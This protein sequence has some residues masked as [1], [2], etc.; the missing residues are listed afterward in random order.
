MEIP[1]LMLSKAIA[2]HWAYYNKAPKII[3][4]KQ[5]YLGGKS[6]EKT[7]KEEC[8]VIAFFGCGVVLGDFDFGFYLE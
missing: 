2:I 4:G 3:V 6:V 7:I 1:E 8:K 5:M